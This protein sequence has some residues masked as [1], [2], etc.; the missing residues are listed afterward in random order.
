MALLHLPT[1]PPTHL[2]ACAGL[3]GSGPEGRGHGQAELLQ[4]GQPVVGRDDVG[5]GEGAA[6]PDKRQDAREGGRE[7]KPAVVSE[8]PSLS[9]PHPS[10]PLFD[11]VLSLT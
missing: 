6:A 7:L 11:C 9:P 10:P 4:R 8:P 1:H 2:H 5:L 3:Y